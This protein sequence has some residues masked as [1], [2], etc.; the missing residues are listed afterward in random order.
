MIKHS[1]MVLGV[2]L[3]TSLS[4]PAVAQEAGDP[5]RGKRLYGRCVTC[6]T[7]EEGRHRVGPS[8]Y[9][10]FDSPAGSAKGYDYSASLAAAGKNG[11][12]WDAKSLSG[13][14]ADPVK[15]MRAYMNDE[16]ASTKMVFRVT[17]EQQRLDIIAY[18]KAV[19]G[20][21]APK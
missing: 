1:K 9:R 2:V 4:A 11:L 5:A 21:Q 6:H 15:F 12:K 7:L 18:L 16:K 19:T 14:M 3:L 20:G 13:Y 17:R 8:L 10:I